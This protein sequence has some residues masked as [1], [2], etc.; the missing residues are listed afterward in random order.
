MKKK[1]IF[2]LDNLLGG[3]AEKVL[4]EILN[5]FDYE[6]FDVELLLLT[7]EGK[8]ID[9]LNNNIKLTY[10]FNFIGKSKINIC[11]QKIIR[12]ILFYIIIYMN[13]KF[14]YKFIFNKNSDIIVAFMEGITTKIVAN[15][16][17]TKKIAW[18]H[19]DVSKYKW[20][21][22]YFINEKEEMECYKQFDKIICVSDVCRNGFINTYGN[23]FD[24]KVIKVYNPINHFIVKQKSLE[25]NEEIKNDNDIKKLCYIGRLEPEKGIMRLLKIL[26]EIKSENIDFK[27]SIIGEGSQ[28]DSINKYIKEHDLNSVVN[29]YGF[30]ENPY[31]Y[32]YASDIIVS[33]SYFE[34]FSLITAEALILNKVIVATDSGG[35][36]EILNNGKYGYVCKNDDVELKKSIIKMIIDEKLFEK[37]KNIKKDII[38]EF[39]I[40]NVLKKIY[41]IIGEVDK[42]NE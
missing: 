41:S 27:L 25:D 13:P 4:I 23:Q 21:K 39:E 9:K 15:I 2:V 33:P 18:I 3:G 37:Y 26:Y 34:G 35:P 29:L 28:K 1:V 38:N 8:Y 24:N 17:S 16:K 22:Y 10:I 19:T 40:T 7:K 5:N 30:Q 31:K 42:K 6:L 32:M 11:I 20:Y 12:K 14:I 36:T